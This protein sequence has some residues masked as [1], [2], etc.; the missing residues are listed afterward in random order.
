[1]CLITVMSSCFPH[2]VNLCYKALL[3][4]IT[5][6]KF[7]EETAADYEPSGDVP[8]TFEE[9]LKKDLIATTC[10]LIRGVWKLLLLSITWVLI[11][12]HRSKH[13]P[14]AATTLLKF[15]K[16]SK[17]KTCS[18]CRMW[19]P[20]GHQHFWWLTRHFFYARFVAYVPVHSFFEL[21]SCS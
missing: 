21:T 16:L 6:L 14:F 11:I 5:D 1:M 9:M 12:Q 4:T 10:S 7:A 15:P 13:H 19:T 3:G 2:I 17:R 18:C 20:D 8:Q